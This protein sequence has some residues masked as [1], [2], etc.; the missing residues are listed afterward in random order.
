MDSTVRFSNRVE[1]YSRY[2]PSYPKEAIDAV[3]TGFD[4]PHVADLGAGTGISARL[5]A[6]AG[7][8]VYAVEP[9]ANM[10]GALPQDERIVPVNGTAESTGLEPISVDIVTAFQA[11]HWFD[12]ERAFAEADRIAKKRARFAAV[13]NERDERDPFTKSYGDI[14]RPYM[15]DDTE[16]T[17]RGSSIDGDLERY[18]WGLGRRIEFAYQQ[19]LSWDA[20]IGRARSAS[21]LPRE[22]PAY[23][24]MAE[25][26]RALYDQHADGTVRFALVTTVHLGERMS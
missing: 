19:P 11:Y 12:P 10:R 24:E 20:L 17:R 3:L 6:D 23:D 5:L 13:W 7:A 26:L 14:I 18:G 15:L 22:G 2:R 9:N 8:F 1:D 16:H 25:K 21:Y 4:E